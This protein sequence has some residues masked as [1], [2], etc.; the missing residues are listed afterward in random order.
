MPGIDPELWMIVHGGLANVGEWPEN[1]LWAAFMGFWKMA[2][3]GTGTRERP[4][5]LLYLGD[6]GEHSPPEITWF[7]AS[8]EPFFRVWE[9]IERYIKDHYDG[10]PLDFRE[11][12]DDGLRDEFEDLYNE[13]NPQDFHDTPDGLIA[14]DL[15]KLADY[16]THHRGTIG[17]QAFR[18]HISSQGDGPFN[19][20]LPN[21]VG[22]DPAGLQRMEDYVV[23]MLRAFVTG[24]EDA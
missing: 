16:A 21:A 17:T 8:R 11:M 20:V 4:S 3:Q 18:F 5:T 14:I 22:R 10:D 12:L 23:D 13:V 19:Y 1:G 9:S 6:P 15:R 2:M 7:E 24:A